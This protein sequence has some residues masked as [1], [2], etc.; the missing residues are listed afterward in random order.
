K[1][2]EQLAALPKD[3]PGFLLGGLKDRELLFTNSLI[4]HEAYFGN[5]G[6]SGKPSG[7]IEK[8]LAAAY[9]DF[10]RWEEEFRGTGAS[11]AGGSGWVVLDL[12]LHT[13]ALRTY[14]SGNH[15]QALASAVPL[16]VMDMYEHAYQID[17]G[18]AA[19]KYVDAFFQNIPWDEVDRRYD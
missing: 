10:G 16:L 14:W 11:L 2:E 12:N 1:V 17:Y 9:R 15:T 7:S 19:G 8:A 13:G 5:L 6:G 3:A 18:A 4:L